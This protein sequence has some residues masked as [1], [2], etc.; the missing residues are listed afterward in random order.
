MALINAGCKSDAG[1]SVQD[2]YE[3]REECII[4]LENNKDPQNVE[5]AQ[6]DSF[7]YQIDYESAGMTLSELEIGDRIVDPSWSWEY[8]TGYGI[9]GSGEERYVIWIL[10]AKDHY[11]GMEPHI[12]LLA[13]ELI[14]YYPFDNSTT[15]EGSMGSNHWGDSGAADATHGL[16]TWLNGTGINEG[17]GFY[18]AFSDDF[19]N[20]VLSTRLPTREW[21]EGEIYFTED[22][23]FI[24]STTELGDRLHTWTY[25][26][27]TAFDF[28]EG[29]EFR[30]VF[31]KLDG[32]INWYWTRSPN[33][34]DSYNVRRVSSR[35][36]KI[37]NAN[38][39]KIAV[40]PAINLRPD[41]G[42]TGR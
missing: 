26:I 16:R 40:R 14:G 18:R 17:E 19:R 10:V 12:T 9:S 11:P 22:K 33:R 5:N 34:F 37:S 24:P 39:G 4:T 2:N 32:D 21:K 31:A 8:R 1:K 15:R 20:A 41:L 36:F 7:Y 29:A 35:D 38:T 23:V 42:I 27:G 30:K 3:N 28:F 6:P 25:E 13:E